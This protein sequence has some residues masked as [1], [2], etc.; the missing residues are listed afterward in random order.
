MART[1]LGQKQ[2]FKA[3][4]DYS[5]KQFYLMYLSAADT[6]TVSGAAGDVIGILY[7]KPTSGAYGEVLTASGVLAQVIT[8]GS[9]SAGDW[10]ESD[11]AGKAVTLTINGDGTTETYT[12]GRAVTASGGTGEYITVLTQFGPASK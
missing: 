10:L 4:A 3:A 9:V 2:S 6:I 8:G 5:G 7:G 1:N 11:S 12:V